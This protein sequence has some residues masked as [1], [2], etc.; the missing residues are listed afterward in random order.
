MKKILICLS[1]VFILSIIGQAEK[2]TIISA[3]DLWLPYVDPEDPQGG[4]SLHV[5]RGAL[6]YQG[7][8]VTHKFVPWARALIGVEDGTYD[9]LPDSW[10]IKE[11]KKTHLYSDSYA[12]S[13]VKFIKRKG[14]PFEY[15]GLKS[16][17]G[18]NVGIVRSYVYTDAFSKASNFK[19]EPVENIIQN[20]NKLIAGRIDL[21][22]DDEIAVIT[23]LRD[24][25]P[26]LLNKIE[27]T[28][29]TFSSNSLYIACSKKNV[30]CKDI[31]KA[32]N[33]G[34]KKIRSDGTYKRIL[35]SYILKE[36]DIKTLPGKHSN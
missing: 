11:R 5:I 17:S 23:V 22:L 29:N 18:R 27:F 28:R 32:F 4:F 35:S 2:K 15:N 25:N 21:T 6:S 13:K 31:I 30:K 36:H 3:A 10:M 16:L 14:D 7:Y 12:V 8:E 20:I 24:K 26:G 19:R 34:L 9:I 1:A 33:K